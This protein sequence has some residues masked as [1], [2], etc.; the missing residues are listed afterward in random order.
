MRLSSI[1]L[2]LPAVLN[3]FLLF[4][5]DKNFSYSARSTGDEPHYVL[6]ARS[7]IYDHDFD[8]KNNYEE[9]AITHDVSGPL[10]W[11]ASERNGKYYSAHGLGLP[12]FVAPSVY[13]YGTFGAKLFLTLISCFLPFVLSLITKGTINETIGN[14][15]SATFCVSLPFLLSSSQIYSD[16]IVS[17]FFV[18]SIYLFYKNISDVN[19]K[20][21]GFVL[22]LFLVL[23][24]LLPWFH[25]K[26][27]SSYLIIFLAIV[28]VLYLKKQKVSILIV[29]IFVFLNLVIL[30][31][32][33]YLINGKVFASNNNPIDISNLFINLKV[34][35]SFLFDSQIGICFLQPLALIG[36]IYSLRF[37]WQYP[38]VSFLTILIFLSVFVAGAMVSWSYIYKFEGQLCNRYC[39]SIYPLL[40]LPIG[41]ELFSSKKIR[42][43]IGIISLILLAVQF[44]KISGL[45]DTEPNKM[46]WSNQNIGLFE[47]FKSML[48]NFYEHILTDANV[49]VLL[50]IA[51]I[52]LF[53]SV[54]SL[55]KW[56]PY[57]QF[58][59]LLIVGFFM[60]RI[61]NFNTLLLPKLLSVNETYQ[62]AL[63]HSIIGGNENSMLSPSLIIK[64]AKPENGAGYLM[65][66]NYKSMK[67]GKYIA[68][69]HFRYFNVVK[70]DVIGALDIYV[71]FGRGIARK[72]IDFDKSQ[73]GK[74]QD[75]SIEFTIEDQFQ[76]GVE[77][78]MQVFGNA[79]VEVDFVRIVKLE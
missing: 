12:I 26:F 36:L 40:F 10:D 50:I 20:N 64:V 23:Y 62:A 38:L 43:D 51:I 66:G 11:H 22:F 6:L 59:I 25:N 79:Q 16:Q 53:V 76:A 29:S 39:W 45:M 55:S 34:G 73:I 58:I 57:S 72:Q 15:A 14:I 42:Y 9:D 68:T 17:V 60:F 35:L 69:Y 2:F 52:T 48:P 67:K 28:Y 49:V 30:S 19:F 33:N 71:G 63:Y 24:F 27:L 56:R 70:E 3:L 77:T 75:A 31:Y 4:H 41:F 46:L 13:F 7:I 65:T 44:T 61:V 21:N 8:L 32:Y 37:I 18:G 74:W 54:P 47:Y 78:L 1:I 5:W